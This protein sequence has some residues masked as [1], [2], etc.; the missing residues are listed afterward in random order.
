MIIPKMTYITFITVFYSGVGVRTGTFCTF[1]DV[2]QLV[3]MQVGH[4]QQVFFW[5]RLW[6]Y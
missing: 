4:R 2:L 3:I 6:D 1:L 5:C